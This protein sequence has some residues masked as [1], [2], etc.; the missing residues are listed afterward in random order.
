[1]L[2]NNPLPLRRRLLEIFYDYLV[3]LAYLL[4]LFSLTMTVYLIV[5]GKIPT[6][7]LWQSQL[8]ATFTSVIPVIL[9]FSFQDSRSGTWG[10]QKAG[11]EI[12]YQKSPLRSALIR[13]SI[14]FL[15]WQLGHMGTIV[16][17]YSNYQDP[18]AYIFSF[19]S[20]SFLLLLLAMTFVRKDKRHLG[21]LLAKTQ[22]LVKGD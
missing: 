9:L 11:L 8:L 22:V 3:I 17:I 12:V 6:F 21:D 2:K 19:L 10:K 1:M 16:G 13:N 5:L 18:M 20:L 15:P 7:G 4:L 14:K